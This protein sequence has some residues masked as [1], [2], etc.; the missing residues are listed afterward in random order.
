MVK[1]RA[2]G[3]GFTEEERESSR[4]TLHQVLRNIIKIL[5]P[6][7]PFITDYIWM[8]LY[9]KESICKESYP[10]LEWKTGMEKFTEKLTEFN[11]KVW[12]M[13]KDQGMS[14]KAEIEIDIPD[15]LKIFE[16]D[17]VRMHNIK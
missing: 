6:I 2:Y 1:S 12:K 10:D 14:M 9:S 15:E 4:Y 13:K 11:S 5:S 3:D 8:E 17:L 7:T 16:K